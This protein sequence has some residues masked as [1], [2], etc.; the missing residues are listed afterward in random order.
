MDE[1]LAIAAERAR[2]G[3]MSAVNFLAAR[4]PD[5]RE[6]ELH[7]LLARLGAARE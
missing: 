5:E 1:L 4:Q 3:N 6:A 2:C 7:R